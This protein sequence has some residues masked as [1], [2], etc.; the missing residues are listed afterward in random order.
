MKKSCLKKNEVKGFVTVSRWFLT[1]LGIQMDLSRTEFHTESKNDLK[2]WFYS[3]F[4]RDTGSV[5]IS[6]YECIVYLLY[7]LHKIRFVL[8]WVTTVWIK[9]VCSTSLVY[10]AVNS[11][12]CLQK[13]WYTIKFCVWQGKSWIFVVHET[14]LFSFFLVVC[15]IW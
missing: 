4:N 12:K 8:P 3:V 1:F 2:M 13:Q 11:S 9:C 14:I 15:R 5:K 6:N 7:K 10:S